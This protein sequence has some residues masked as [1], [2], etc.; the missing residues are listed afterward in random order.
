MKKLI[1]LFLFVLPQ[2]LLAQSIVSTGSEVIF[3]RPNTTVSTVDGLELKGSSQNRLSLPLSFDFNQLSPYNNRVLIGNSNVVYQVRSVSTNTRADFFTDIPYAGNRTK[4]EFALTNKSATGDFNLRLQQSSRIGYND[5]PMEWIVSKSNGNVGDS[6]DLIFS[7]GEELEPVLIPFKRLFVFDPATEE[8]EQLPED[9]TTVDEDANRLTFSEYEGSLSNTRFMLAQAIPQINLNGTFTDILWCPEIA[10]PSQT[11]TVEAFDLTNDLTLTAPANFEI[12]LSEEGAYLNQLVIA[13]S[14]G[15]VPLTTLYVRIKA[16]ASASGT[17]SIE[18]SS[19]DDTYT[20]NSPSI[21]ITS[22]PDITPPVLS[23]RNLTLSLDDNGRASFNVEDIDTGST[24]DCNVNLY[25]FP[26]VFSCGDVGVNNV[27]VFGIDKSGN[28]TFSDITVTVLDDIFP[29]IIAPEALTIDADTNCTASGFSLG[30]PVADDNCTG[31]TV[32]NNAPSVFLIGTTTVTW[33][34]TDASGNVATDTQ[35]VTV[36][37]TTPPTITGPGLITVNATD[38]CTIANDDVDFQLTTNDNCAVTLL[39]NDGPIA[40]D[41]GFTTIVWTISDAAGNTSN[42]TQM[43]RVVDNSGPVFGVLADIELSA[44]A[45]CEVTGYSLSNPQV[46]DNCSIA[47]IT[48]DAPLS[49]PIGTTTVTWTATDVNGNQSTATQ[50]VIVED[51]L[52]PVITCPILEQTYNNTEGFC[53]L[54]VTG[55][56]FDA[57]ATDNCEVISLTHNYGGANSL[58]TLAGATF[59]VGT[60]PVTWTATD[61]AGN[62]S[63]CTIDVV[64]E[65]KEAPVFTNFPPSTLTLGTFSC[66]VISNWNIPTVADNCGIQSLVQTAGPAPDAVL[67][68]G[69]YTVSYKVTDIHGNETIQSFELLVD[70]SNLPRLVCPED[71]IAQSTDTGSCT[72]IADET[73]TPKQATGNCIDLTWSVVFPDASIVPGSGSVAGTEFPLGT[74]TLTYRVEDNSNQVVTCTTQITVVDSELPIISAP[75]AIVIGADIGECTASGVNL[76]TPTTLDNCGVASVINDAPLQYPLGMT[77]V[78]W[79]VIDNAGN[80]A[81]ATQTVTV[82]DNESP[83]ITAPN[84]ITIEVDEYCEIESPILGDPVI[85]DNCGSVT[86]TNDAPA[87][88]LVGETL[89][90]WTATDEAGNTATDTQLIK[91]EDK[92]APTFINCPE[93]ITIGTYTGC[94]TGPTWK[95]PIPVDNCGI[96]SFSQISGPSS[97]DVLAAGTYTVT[98]RAV[99]HSGNSSDCS[100]DITVTNDSDPVIV[101]MDDITVST[102][103]PAGC[104]W[105][106][107]PNSLSLILAEG[108]CPVEITYTITSPSGTITNG[109]GDASGSVFQAGTSILTYT[110]TDNDGKTTSCSSEVK[111]IE[112]SPPTIIAPVDLMV[113]ADVNC[114]AIIEDLGNPISSDNCG[115]VAVRND[116]PADFPI[117]A[118]TVTWTATDASG[119]TA[120]ATQIIT[121]ED[122][123]PPAITGLPSNITTGNDVGSCNAAV[124]WAEPTVT[125]NCTAVAMTSSHNSGDIFTLGTTTVTYTATK[126][127]LVIQYAQVYTMTVQTMLPE[128]PTITFQPADIWIV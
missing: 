43:I 78:T 25:A 5:I 81:T 55:T 87:V 56:V 1:L 58:N 124:T 44:D 60:T 119:N 16:T 92:I 71:L 105:I 115:I 98:Y 9:N 51:E 24:D 15:K 122:N 18:A 14:N 126:M 31:F 106:S 110:V 84:D 113:S 77:T 53:G 21:S 80:T 127:L 79:T 82:Q 3:V 83:T 123:T 128:N 32:T 47:S 103:D 72:W 45:N 35:E 108:N 62:T 63:S 121:V 67:S 4:A 114:G 28:I 46:T 26:N 8:W 96:A 85:A 116:A 107:E 104:I 120:T 36:V 109:T 37:D 61:A 70:D 97:G 66:G 40:F 118:T 89:V 13:P 68:V 42:F 27:L 50:N 23:L 74:S 94:A 90:T 57:Q 39:E 6:Q 69:T 20:V 19:F 112:K 10:S 111:V 76:G 22:I 12:A 30:N 73:L 65:D 11:F 52:A 88:F 125:D 59:P 17:F 2:Y 102:S 33:T 41:L 101:C 34:I 49:F 29:T 95:A 64:V 117:G 93:D 99:D 48:N 75:V 38:N 7:W 86:V 100:F 54:L 91:V